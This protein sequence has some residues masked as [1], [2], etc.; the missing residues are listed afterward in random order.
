MYAG[1]FACVHEYVY[2]KFYLCTDLEKSMSLF[3]LA[4]LLSIKMA[5]TETG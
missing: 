1:K 2:G 4:A 5:S 3:L